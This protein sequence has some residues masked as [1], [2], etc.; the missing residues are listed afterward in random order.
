MDFLFG[1]IKSTKSSQIISLTARKKIK[2][3]F[4]ISLRHQC[5]QNNKKEN[6][7]KIKI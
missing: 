7:N 4:M 5:Q 6:L 3:D 1:I 2:S